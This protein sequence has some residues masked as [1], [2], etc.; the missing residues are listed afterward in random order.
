M[1]SL[2]QLSGFL[3]AMGNDTQPR[4]NYIFVD[5][6]NVH[7]MDLDRI[8]QKPVKVILVLG[9]Q[10]KKLAV[11]LVRKLLQYADQVRL[12]E[13]GRSGKNASD[14]VLANCI[15]EV[16]KVDPNGYIH[17]IS[18]D[19]DFDALIG[20][21]MLNG[22]LAAR[23]TSF[24]EIP[25][26]MNVDERA[27][28]V[29]SHFQIANASRPKSRKALAAHIQAVFGKVLSSEEVDATIER[30]I[31]QKILTLSE[32][33][34][35]SYRISEPQTLTSPAIVATPLPLGRSEPQPKQMAPSQVSSEPFTVVL[36]HLLEHTNNRPTRKTTLI[37]HLITVLGKK[38]TEA[39]VMVIV[40]K[41]VSTKQLAIDEN[42]RVSYRF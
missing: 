23:R 18:K 42:N 33:N 39:E 30:L 35:I 37:R 32:K 24:S 11:P 17:I 21:Y 20:H 10:H 9:D 13:T 3:R 36:N 27:M 1:F 5:F 40:G 15:G 29:A 16:K 4:V 28:L 34:E 26:L 31:A 25:V 12:V 7:E 6:E 22:A 19:K 8:A 38:V 14:F 2:L 41:L